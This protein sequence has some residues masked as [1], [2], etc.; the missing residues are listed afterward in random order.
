MSDQTMELN[1]FSFL[2]L[3]ERSIAIGTRQRHR[4][5]VCSAQGVFRKLPGSRMASRTP[6]ILRCHRLVF[7]AEFYQQWCYSR[8]W[9]TMIYFDTGPRNRGHA[10][11]NSLGWLL[12]NRHSSA[13]LNGEKS[14]NA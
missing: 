12:D 5:S 10:R 2:N 9:Q 8:R 4:Y 1:E 6:F 3:K 11:R 14:R 13:C 7:L